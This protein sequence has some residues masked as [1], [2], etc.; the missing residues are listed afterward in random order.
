[1]EVEEGIPEPQQGE[2]PL[3]ASTDE[4]G[5]APLAVEAPTSAPPRTDDA[6]HEEGPSAEVPLPSPWQQEQ[7]PQSVSAQQTHRGN[8]LKDQLNHATVMLQRVGT[9]RSRSRP[10]TSSAALEGHDNIMLQAR[11]ARAKAEQEV[12]LLMNRLHH[13]KVRRLMVSSTLK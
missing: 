1:M 4:N 6:T 8:L 3:P 11:K 5:V 13:L 12:K 10:K 7:R 9:A 2:A